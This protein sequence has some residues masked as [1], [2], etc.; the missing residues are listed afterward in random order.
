MLQRIN[1]V[2]KGI[3]VLV[4]VFL[5]ANVFDAGLPLF[6]FAWATLLTFLFGKVHIKVWLFLFAPCLFLAAVTLWNAVLFPAP[7]EQT[8]AV[9]WTFWWVEVTTNTLENGL[10]LSARVLAFTSLSLL[11]VLTTKPTEF[12][13]S[14][15]QQA[16]LPPKLA[17]SIL[18][19]YRFLPLIRQEFRHLQQAGRIRGVRR[20]RTPTEKLKQIK[21]TTVPLLALAIRK[22]EQT[23]LS[24]EA[25]GFTGSRK[26]TYYHQMTISY[27]DG[28]FP[29]LV[30]VPFLVWWVL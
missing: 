16:R 26:R 6:Y 18:A 27:L 15:M 28:I 24:M 11:F 22:A 29:V 10:S 20:A 17:Y 21:R 3:S 2:V 30:L 25:R 1:P 12:M 7:A 14:A 13:L 8:G 5:L 23:A 9:L 19:G 4:P